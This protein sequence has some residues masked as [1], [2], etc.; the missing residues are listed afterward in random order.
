MSTFER[1][2]APSPSVW[3]QIEMQLLT[4][5]QTAEVAFKQ[6]TGAEKEQA[7]E[8]Y[9]Q[10]LAR[11]SELIIDRRFPSDIRLAH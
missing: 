8:Q 2:A 4:D 6:A 10:A 3:H 7:G 5:V 9:R 11:F 1:N